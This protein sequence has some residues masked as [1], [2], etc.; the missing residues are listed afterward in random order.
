MV[1]MTRFVLVACALLAVS[2]STGVAQTPRPSARTDSPIFVFETNE[3]WLNLHHFLY[4]LGRA[5]LKLPD[6]SS[7]SI[8]NAPVENERGLAG[9][10]PEERSA[11]SESITA[12]AAG[13]SRRSLVFDQAMASITGALSQA[14]DRPSLDGIA[15]DADVRKVLERAAPISR[16]AWWPTHRQDNDA[17]RTTLQAHVDR[18]G[19]PI[20]DFITRAYDERWPAT[21]YPVHL[22]SY[23][24]RTGN[25][26]TY[27]NL[28]VVSSTP[29]PG[30]NGLLPLE[31]IF[32]EAMHQWDDAIE[33]ALRSRGL[34]LDGR[35]PQNLTHAL[36]W[37]T[38]GEAVR[39][40]DASH[41]PYADAIGIW[42][43]RDVGPFRTALEE[44]WRPRL[45]GRG[46]RDEAF[47]AL[48]AR[49]A[50]QP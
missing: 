41:V 17:F 31:I 18:H 29:Q 49:L 35:G 20:L 22:S 15:I 33:A 42:K 47:S 45:D 34:K 2:W 46:T 6:V 7:P 21:G 39:R 28:L 19:R 23:V 24:D 12:Y 10:T 13:Y 36:I 26:S 40:V 5:Q 32:H 3:L 38:A 27:G 43:G 25:Y 11:W 50:S 37:L 30:H 4:V 9:L 14:D 16:K 1:R 44:T 8:V 48:V